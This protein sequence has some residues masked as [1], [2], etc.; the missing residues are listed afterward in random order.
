MF[1]YLKHHIK[2]WI[3]C[4]TIFLEDWGEVYLDLNWS[5]L[6]S[7]AVEEIP[8]GTKYT[9][10]KLG[11]IDTFVISDYAQKSRQ[12]VTGLIMFPKTNPVAQ[13]V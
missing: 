12:Y 2:W 11:I 10:S 9:K 5:D 8:P 3:V 13:Q 7:D 4:D 6:Y 1:G